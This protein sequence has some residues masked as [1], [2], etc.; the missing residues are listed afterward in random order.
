MPAKKTTILAADD[1]PQILRLVR[2]NLQ[3]DGYEVIAVTDGQAALDHI[4]TEPPDLV[5]LDVRMPHVDGFQVIQRVRTFSSAPILLLTSLGDDTDKIRGLD[6]GADDYLTKP[7]S[8]EEL[9]ARVRAVIRRSQLG[10]HGVHGL[11]AKTTVGELEVDYVQHLVTKRGQEL[12]LTPTEY[13][14]LAYLAQNAG[15]VLPYD[16]LLEQVWGTD[17]LG[18]SHMLQVVMNRLRHKIE[19]DH[20]RCRLCASSGD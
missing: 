13:R 16:A 19:E 8:V 12:S 6:L 7:F 5:V 10:A 11:S 9:L 14:L 3:F 15:R 20:V 18:E 2:R 17:Y 4:E 1:D